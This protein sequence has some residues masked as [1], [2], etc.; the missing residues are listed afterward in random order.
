[1][2]GFKRHHSG[3][4]TQVI[5]KASEYFCVHFQSV[6]FEQKSR[7]FIHEAARAQRLSKLLML[8]WKTLRFTAPALMS[9]FFLNFQLAVR[10]H[11]L[12]WTQCEDINQI[13]LL[14]DAYWVYWS[15]SAYPC[16]LIVFAAQDETLISGYWNSARNQQWQGPRT[17]STEVTMTLRSNIVWILFNAVG[18]SHRNLTRS[19]GFCWIEMP[20]K[21]S[22]SPYFG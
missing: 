7:G 8:E 5:Q 20:V 6:A 4:Q 16:W 21:F 18:Q 19:T 1:M 12:N 3:S 9:S 14:F 15:L 2:C 11:P 17:A 13:R 22:S 10:T